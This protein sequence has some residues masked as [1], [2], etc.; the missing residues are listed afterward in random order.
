MGKSLACRLGRHHW[1]IEKRQLDVD[2]PPRLVQVCVACQRVDFGG[3]RFERTDLPEDP[4][5]TGYPP[6]FG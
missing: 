6:G 5:G 3:S 4:G 2:E 1:E